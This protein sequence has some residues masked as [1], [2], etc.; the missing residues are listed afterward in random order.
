[1]TSGRSDLVDIE[2]KLVH[3]TEKAYLLKVG[4]REAW[5]PKSQVE[6]NGDGTFTMPEELAVEKEIEDGAV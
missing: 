1:M 4:D 3:Q 2:A 5:V 6:D